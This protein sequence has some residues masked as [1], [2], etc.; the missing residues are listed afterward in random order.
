MRMLPRYN[1][2]TSNY[3]VKHRVPAKTLLDGIGGEVRKTLVD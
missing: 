3:P 1:V 2:L